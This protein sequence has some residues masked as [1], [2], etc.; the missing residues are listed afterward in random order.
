MTSASGS[1]VTSHIGLCVSDIARSKSFYCDALGFEPAALLTAGKECA[2]LVGVGDDLAIECQFLLKDGALIELV[3]FTRPGHFG[4][5]TPRPHN[6]LGLTHLS[7][8]VRNLDA[9]VD[10]IVKHGGSAI[11][12]TR[13]LQEPFGRMIFCTD[14]DGIKIELMEIPDSIQFK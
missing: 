1:I 13:I 3:H 5:T 4:P 11:E 10:D 7:F 12:S 2:D 14:P 8:R 9:V 6:Q